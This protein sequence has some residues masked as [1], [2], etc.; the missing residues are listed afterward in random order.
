M[1]P[2]LRIPRSLKILLPDGDMILVVLLFLFL[3]L[4]VN[5]RNEYHA[6][7]MQNSVSKAEN[8]FES[9]ID[10]NIDERD[11]RSG[12]TP[13]MMSVLMGR[14][15]LVKFFLEKGADVTI[16]E[17]DG[18]TPVHGAGF[19]GRADI[20]EIL[21]EHGL[22]PNDRHEDGFTPL[23]RACWGREE[24]HT[25]TVRVLLD[26]GV[27]ATQPD[28]QGRTCAVLTNNDNTLHLIDDIRKHENL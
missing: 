10:A 6:A 24:R 2:F 12:Q 17:K 9:D 25:E 15:D 26:A 20:M 27:P 4:D 18:Y 13:L 14:T 21:I 11:D 8:I 28:A 19:Q 7:V 16:P 1:D 22:D 23:H 3:I 5:G